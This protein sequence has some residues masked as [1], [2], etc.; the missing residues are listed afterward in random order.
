MTVIEVTSEIIGFV[1]KN[2]KA[3]GDVVTEGE[4]IMILESMK[5]EIAVEAPVTGT[6]L[7]IKVATEESVDEGQVLC[8]IES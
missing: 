4:V 1:R 7:K 2:E 6:I 8:L 3:E 5:M